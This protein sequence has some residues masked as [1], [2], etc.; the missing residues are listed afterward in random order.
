VQAGRDALAFVSVHIRCLAVFTL[1]QPMVFKKVDLD[2]IIFCTCQVKQ[3]QGQSDSQ[4]LVLGR[5]MG[6][7]VATKLAAESATGFRGLIVQS[8]FTSYK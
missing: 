1:S 6:N 5:S 4:L 2:L 8:G 7:G 3:R